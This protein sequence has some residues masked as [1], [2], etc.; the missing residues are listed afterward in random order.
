M[1]DLS[2]I[3]V[4]G[5][6][7]LTPTIGACNFFA[8]VDVAKAKMPD[9]K[10]LY[11]KGRSWTYSMEA[12]G[13]DQS[14]TGTMT[15]TVK[16]VEKN[17]ATIETDVDGKKSTST[18]DLKSTKDPYLLMFGNPAG[19]T[20]TPK[21]TPSPT[22]S[23]DAED[24]EKD[25]DA[26]ASPSPKPSAKASTSTSSAF[27]PKIG[28]TTNEKVTVK[29]GTYDAMKQTATLSMD[30]FGAKMDS[31][32]ATWVNVD[33]GLVKMTM[34]MK[35]TAPKGA[36]TTGNMPGELTTTYELTSFK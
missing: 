10:A 19:T 21:P 30:F 5:A 1:R 28:E 22:P 3:L 25:D 20:A 18:M 14:K 13:G 35:M 24:A 16:K 33:V 29:A 26:K 15:M 12:K 23:D 8:G 32:Y 2:A 34:T 4:V 9:M 17:V 31:S 6:L 27:K 7:A 11:V 36:K